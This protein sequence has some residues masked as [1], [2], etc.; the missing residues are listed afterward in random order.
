[1]VHLADLVRAAALDG[2]DARRD[3][4]QAAVLVERGAAGAAAGE[5]GVGLY[6]GA[7]GDVALAGEAGDAA[8]G[9]A[10]RRAADAGVADERELVAG[11]EAG[12]AAERHRAPAQPGGERAAVERRL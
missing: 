1:Q 3:R 9:E 8:G 4:D 6:P 11:H 10:H 2:A 5:R 7:A 12:G